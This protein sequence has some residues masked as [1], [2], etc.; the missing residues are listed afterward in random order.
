MKGVDGVEASA[1]ALIHDLATLLQCDPS[2][3]QALPVLRAISGAIDQLLPRLPPSFLEPILPPDSLNDHQVCCHNTHMMCGA[4]VILC[5]S[6]NCHPK[7]APSALK[8]IILL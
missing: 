3:A 1:S 2:P 7:L 5:Q 4:P 8:C 6:L